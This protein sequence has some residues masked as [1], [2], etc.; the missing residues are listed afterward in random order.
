M[1]F[2]VELVLAHLLGQELL[3]WYIFWAL[4]VVKTKIKRHG[5]HVTAITFNDFLYFI[6]RRPLPS[7]DH[8]V[9]IKG[10]SNCEIY[11]QKSLNHP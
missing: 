9:S 6:D 5:Y 11:H 10:G 3:A 7:R 8:V 1:I 2:S 4:K